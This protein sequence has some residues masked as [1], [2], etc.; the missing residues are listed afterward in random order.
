[1]FRVGFL[2]GG[3]NQRMV[4]KEKAMAEIGVAVDDALANDTR[5]VSNC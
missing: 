1:M 4:K 5:R 2:L 3:D